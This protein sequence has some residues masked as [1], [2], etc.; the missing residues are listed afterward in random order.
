MGKK[1]NAYNIFVTKPDGRDHLEDLGVDGKN[2]L[3]WI[4]GKQDGRL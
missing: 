4:L 2:I 1:R 3:Q